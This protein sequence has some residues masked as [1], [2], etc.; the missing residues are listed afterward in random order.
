MDLVFNELSVIKGLPPTQ[1]E[2]FPLLNHML[3][4]I[5]NYRNHFKHRNAK[6]LT[7]R[8]LKDCQLSED[9]LTTIE[10]WMETLSQERKSLFKVIF[11]NKPLIR[12]IPPYYYFQG[13]GA[14][15]FAYAYENGLYSISYNNTIW[16]DPDYDIDMLTDD[17][18]RVV[19]VKHI[20]DD[21]FSEEDS[22][23][24][25]LT[26]GRD[27]WE[28]KEDIFSKLVFCGNTE[29]QILSY[30]KD[31]KLKTAYDK[32]KKLNEEL[33]SVEIEKFNYKDV[34]ISISPESESTLNQFSAERTFQIPNTDRN[35]VFELHIK[36][37]EWRIY[38]YVDK[39]TDK[40]YIGHI[41]NHLRT[42]NF[43]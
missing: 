5:I 32:L 20:T 29:R 39:E 23:Y 41:G 21:L 16:A 11:S 36:T 25:S 22:I 35:E 27:L 31:K 19:N 13:E 7:S 34:G 37:G 9:A 17:D 43:K 4:Q 1:A 14:T 28:R 30:G 6:V 3:Q 12:D 8:S 33:E 42:A 10:Q 38:F 40:C 2:A 18:E 26:H 15:G 24:E